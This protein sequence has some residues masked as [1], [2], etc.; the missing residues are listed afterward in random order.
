MT[1]MV[2]MAIEFENVGFTGQALE[3]KY[4]CSFKAL[5]VG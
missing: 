5:K 2:G 3:V 4:A 1:V